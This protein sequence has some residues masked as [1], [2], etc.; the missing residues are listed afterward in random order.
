MTYLSAAEDHSYFFDSELQGVVNDFERA[1]AGKSHHLWLFPD[2]TL[3][4]NRIP[5]GMAYLAPESE[6]IL[7]PHLLRDPGCGFLSFRVNLDY[8]PDANWRHVVGEC[9]NSWLRERKSASINITEALYSG[10][11]IFDMPGAYPVDREQVQLTAAEQ[12]ALEN[13]LLHVTNSVE[14]RQIAECQDPIALRQMALGA[15]TLVGFIHSGSRAFPQI[16]HQRFTAEIAD[17]AKQ[18][19]LFTDDQIKRGIYGIPLTSALGQRYR[20]WIHAAMNYCQVNRYLIYLK[21]KAFMA[22]KFDAQLELLNDTVHAGLVAVNYQ[23]QSLWAQ[24]RGVQTAPSYGESELG[25][26]AGQ[27]ETMATLVAPGVNRAE[28]AGLYSHGASYQYQ[29][30]HDYASEFSAQQR[31]D[32]INAAKTAYCNAD[33]KRDTCLAYSDNL[34]RAVK[35]FNDIGLVKPI[36][37][38]K[39]YITL[40]SSWLMTVETELET[41][42]GINKLQQKMNEDRN[43]DA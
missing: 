37:Y 14:I 34:L 4:S 23:Q 38:L 35:H 39:P 18:Q 30:D 2:A 24:I 42:L 1:L 33:S 12:Q 13:D 20:H 31:D 26:I 6:A 3:K 15:E 22:E 27:R 11:S 19:S 40:Q 8:I 9:L 32:L 5:T 36:A 16:L 41:E 21:L 28:Y 29:S 10:M 17:Y 25:I 43:Y 7:F